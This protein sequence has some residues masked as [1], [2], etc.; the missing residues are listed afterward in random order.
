[1]VPQ[2]MEQQRFGRY[3]LNDFW[4]HAPGIWFAGVELRFESERRGI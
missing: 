1:M 4:P 2:V 3:K